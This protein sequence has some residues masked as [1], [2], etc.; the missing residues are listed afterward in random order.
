MEKLQIYEINLN[1]PKFLY[2]SSG[3]NTDSF[4]TNLDDSNFKNNFLDDEKSES[5]I[6]DEYIPRVLV[7]N[8]PIR[9]DMVTHEMIQNQMSQSEKEFYIDVCRKLYNEVYEL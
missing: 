9:F 2:M 5:E 7:G 6:K 3:E 8:K 4:N 1:K